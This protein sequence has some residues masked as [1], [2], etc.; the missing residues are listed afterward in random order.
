MCYCPYECI[1]CVDIIDNGWRDKNKNRYI[2]K[3]YHHNLKLV[4]NIYTL[5]CGN[6]HGYTDK[7]G[8][9]ITYDLC[10]KCYMKYRHK[11]D[12]EAGTC[13]KMYKKKKFDDKWIKTT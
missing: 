9:V 4:T 11:A 3:A 5:K 12:I 7:D 2:D 1:I 6:K 8:L 10:K 13:L